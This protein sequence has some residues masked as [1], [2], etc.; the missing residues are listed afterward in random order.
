MI[1]LPKFKEDATLE[2]GEPII[3]ILVHEGGRF[4]YHFDVDNLYKQ[5]SLLGRDKFK[6]S[7]LSEFTKVLAMFYRDEEITIYNHRR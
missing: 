2:A 5:L 4:D 6:K 1:K 7:L 3:T